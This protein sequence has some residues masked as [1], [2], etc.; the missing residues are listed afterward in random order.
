MKYFLLF[1]F[2]FL[3]FA[4]CKIKNIN[5]IVYYNKV[6]HID[7][8]YRFSNDTLLAIKS[9]KKLFKK[10]G[11]NNQEKLREFE[12][13]ILL[14]HLK[15]KK[16]GGKK[17]LYKLI[18]LI[19]P[20]KVWYQ[21]YTFF[22]KYGIDSLEVLRRIKKREGKYNKILNDSFQIAY[23]R[24]QHF[25]QNDN[26]D[27]IKINDLKNIKLFKWTLD[28]FGFPSAEKIG[29]LRNNMYADVQNTLLIHVP[30]YNEAFQ[31]YK[32]ELLKFVK[33]GECDPYDYAIM[34]DRQYTTFIDST[35]SL[36]GLYN[37]HETPPYD[38]LRIDKNRR[39]IGLRG[40]KHNSK[41]PKDMKQILII[42]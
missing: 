36:Y 9:Y 3:F 21:D 26:I 31:F 34:I 40:L 24:D 2:I 23:F 22:T 30:A 19:T 20:N 13:Y 8:I 38:T 25:R 6:N 28:N 12:I 32:K 4:S 10:Q 41:V 35:K 16:F 5:H 33:S 15:N 42:K 17:S 14:S 39:A 27:L 11:Y 1:S 7:S 29:P 18:D 37:P